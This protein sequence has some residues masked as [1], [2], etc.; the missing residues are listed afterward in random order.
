MLFGSSFFF[1]FFT[2][3]GISFF[4]FLF[5]S[6]FFNFNK[7]KNDL[8]KSYLN[9]EKS[10]AE[11][12]ILKDSEKLKSIISDKIKNW[13]K[14]LHEQN[15]QIKILE[16]ELQKTE[17]YIIAD[18]KIS[19]LLLFII[20]ILIFLLIF[21]NKE[22]KIIEKK[23]KNILPY[24]EELLYSNKQNFQNSI[25]SISGRL[26]A[27]LILKQSREEDLRKQIKIYKKLNDFT[28]I[29]IKS[30][31]SYKR[32]IVETQKNLKDKIKL[33]SKKTIGYTLN[34]LKKI[35]VNS[36]TYKNFLEKKLKNMVDFFKKV[37]LNRLSKKKTILQL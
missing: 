7:L 23:Y 21:L 22:K 16:N 30:Q 18:Y 3:L 29:V 13:Q 25:Q 9:S 2:V 26:D 14:Q 10:N 11:A 32:G 33:I 19:I 20:L 15:K 8:R 17:T 12:E 36:L 4:I 1:F 27:A 28:D 35:T 5:F 31:I 34:R 37:S 6:F 24:V